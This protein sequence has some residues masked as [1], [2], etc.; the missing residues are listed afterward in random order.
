MPG[1]EW[2]CMKYNW[3]LTKEQQHSGCTEYRLKPGF[4]D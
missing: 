2:H 3:P 1:G 4:N